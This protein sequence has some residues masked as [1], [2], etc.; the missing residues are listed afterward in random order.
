[1]ILFR[2]R[3]AWNYRRNLVIASPQN[4]GKIASLALT[5]LEKH[6]GVVVIARD[7]ATRQYHLQTQIVSMAF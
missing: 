6:Q 5:T 4:T 7:Y 3:I 1:M 2:A